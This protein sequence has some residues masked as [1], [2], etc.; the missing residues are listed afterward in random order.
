M[1]EEMLAAVDAASGSGLEKLHLLTRY[2]D[3]VCSF[4]V[5]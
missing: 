5:M 4:N 3:K 1:V 2:A